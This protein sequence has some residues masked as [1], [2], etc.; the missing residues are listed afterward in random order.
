MLLSE[1]PGSSAVDRPRAPLAFG[2]FTFERTSRLLRRGD[3]ELP[4]PPRVLGVLE[5]LLAR[6]G[7]VVGRQ[8]LIDGVWKEAFV[9][10]TSLAE[11]VSFLRQALGDDPQSPTY[12]QT[13]HRRGYRFVAPVIEPAPLPPPERT[14]A[15][16]GPAAAPGQASPD[17]RVSPSIGGQLV[18]WSIA[19]LCAALAAAALWQYTSRQPSPPPVVRLRVEPVSGTTFD[20][21]A[22]A[23]ALSPDGT[24]LAWSACHPAVRLE[25]SASLPQAGCRLYTRPLD[26]LAPSVIAG[27]EDASA[28]FF[29]PDGRWVGFFAAG[30]LRKVALAGGLP[31]SITDAP[32]PL[33]GAWLADGRIIFASSARGGLMRVS[34]RGGDAVAVTTP[35]A[36]AGE[37]GHA[38]PAAMPGG[39]GLL[40]TITTSP[41]ESSG[42]R[43]AV[44]DLDAPARWQTIIEAADVARPASGDYIAYARGGELHAVPFDRVR[45][46]TA[47][48]GQ[49]VV[50]G[51]ADGQFTTSDRGDLAYVDGLG[52]R[53]Q[54]A[55]AWLGGPEISGAS[56]QTA[57][58]RALS[59]SPDG[60][61]V[62]GV[63]ADPPGADIWI[64]DLA[65]GATTRLT[66]GG[67]N[68][69]PVWSGDGR[70]IFYASSH[71]GAFEIRRRDAAGAAPETRVGAGSSGRHALP[72]SVSR[73]GR[74]LVYTESGGLTRGDIVMTA[75]DRPEPLVLVNGPFDE[76]G[77]MLSP[78][79]ASL[80]YQSDESGRWEVSLLRIRDRRRLP[81]STQGGAAPLWSPD[82]RAVFYVASSRLVRVDVD[83]SG[84]RAG[85]PVEVARLDDAIAA[86]IALDGKIL[87]Q[88]SPTRSAP[89]AVLTLEW[90]RE[91]RQR[92]GPPVSA[93]PR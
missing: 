76:T 3:V 23:L 24:L 61:R 77:G 36:V 55:L 56:P 16:L 12:I 50:T 44:L 93:L 90:L 54:T 49:V 22:P 48:A 21:R 87:L 45:R 1:A 66:H 40:F 31:V 58:W 2:P 10:D 79:G 62:A 86:G 8:E 47:G 67:V 89:Q 28:P 20:R 33:G 65:R 17:E 68:V 52:S 26:A 81:L 11:A 72:S 7:D 35:S 51:M 27:S 91:L 70:T 5:L 46:V 42:G 80:L 4:L 53:P 59:L 85:S 25:V 14:A 13:V 15:V 88:R 30:K 39:A 69:A 71:G 82:G 29:S 38:W 73:D 6:A 84:E 60:R 32:Q 92:L 57:A 83:P 75:V 37:M 78:D 43:V 63:G 34:D 19:V 18:P 74:F 64:A 9:T 41:L